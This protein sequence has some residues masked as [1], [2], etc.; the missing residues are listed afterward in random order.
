[1][2]F[3]EEIWGIIK[4]YQINYKISWHKKIKTIIKNIPTPNAPITGPRVIYCNRHTWYDCRL[5][6]CLYHIPRFKN[7]IH[8]KNK[9]ETY[10]IIVYATYNH[11]HGVSMALNDKIVVD[12]Y[13]SYINQSNPY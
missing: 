7:S 6:R 10:T 5:L 13:W 3:P 9:D 12:D 1:M 4:R 8:M 11:H 2:W